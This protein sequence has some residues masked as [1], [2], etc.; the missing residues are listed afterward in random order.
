MGAHPRFLSVSWPWKVSGALT[1]IMSS[2]VKRGRR[3][4]S[5]LLSILRLALQK[6]RSCANEKLEGGLFSPR[7]PSLKVHFLQPQ[8]LQIQLLTPYSRFWES[9]SGFLTWF[10]DVHR[11]IW[12]KTNSFWAPRCNCVTDCSVTNS[13]GRMG[14]CVPGVH[15]A[16]GC[17][18][19]WMCWGLRPLSCSCP[20]GY[21]HHDEMLDWALLSQRWKSFLKGSGVSITGVRVGPREDAAPCYPRLSLAPEADGE[22]WKEHH[23]EWWLPPRLGS[24]LLDAF[25]KDS[26]SRNSRKHC[27]KN[28]ILLVL[29][30]I[31][32]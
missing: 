8:W 4:C 24:T 1:F 9:V 29:H 6:Y 12:P 31:T 7:S 21:L 25:G 19:G 3:V 22:K 20:A 15:P 11:V 14:I 28:K 27:R 13:H 26:K 2:G 30:T 16:F 23:D 18:L 5:L 32:F 10:W 17:T